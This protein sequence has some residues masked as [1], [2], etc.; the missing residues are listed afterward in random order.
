MRV[1]YKCRT[2]V[3]KR[4]E[5]KLS[6]DIICHLSDRFEQGTTTIIVNRL[7]SLLDLQII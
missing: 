2:I 5:K 6:F 3:I 1:K 4:E 7:K